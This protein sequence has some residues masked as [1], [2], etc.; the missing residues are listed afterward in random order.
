MAYRKKTVRNHKLLTLKRK[1]RR[2][3][4]RTSM[5]FC[6]AIVFFFVYSF[7]FNQTLLPNFLITNIAKISYKMNYV[8]KSIEVF[9]E[10]DNCRVA[11]IS[12]LDKYKGVPTLVV[13]VDDIRADLESVDCIG[14]VSVSRV[15]PSK[16]KIMV[17]PK[18][19][20]AI[21]QHKHKF[22]FIAENGSVLEIR[23]NK[24][25]NKFIII[26]GENAPKMA[27]QLLK[28]I[29]K[30][31]DLPQKVISAIWIG[32]RRWNVTF[33]NG[34]EI[35]LPEEKYAKAWDKLVELIKS[36]EA[37]KSFSYRVIDFRVPNR[38]YAK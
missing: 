8:I 34:T 5:L 32:D 13:S 28:I 11:D 25:I 22:F 12:V 23:N 27:P 9:G 15:L 1:I 20:I 31:Q 4:I 7:Y 2:W 6:T 26:V 14:K 10:D 19:P 18:T 16:L 24:D 35:L 3:W 30:D 33:D 37:F 29:T 38:I 21:W 36:N 17:E